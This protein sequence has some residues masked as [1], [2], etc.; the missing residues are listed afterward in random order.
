MKVYTFENQIITK[1]LSSK[2][3]L[4]INSIKKTHLSRTWLETRAVR[5]KK[6]FRLTRMLS[7]SPFNVSSNLKNTKL[8]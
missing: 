2:G 1:F 4:R 5:E 8:K 3:Y 6:I 7:G